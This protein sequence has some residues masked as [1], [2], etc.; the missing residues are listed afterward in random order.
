MC[1]NVFEFTAETV[2]IGSEVPN[3]AGQKPESGPA[4]VLPNDVFASKRFSV[5]P[6]GIRIDH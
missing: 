3:Q 6:S 4:N 5:N 2:V 1:V